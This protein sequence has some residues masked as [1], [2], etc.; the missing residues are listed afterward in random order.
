MVADNSEGL[1]GILEKVYHARG[2]DFR[3]YKETTITR[4]L[5]RR[6]RAR[7]VKTY[8]E[9]ARV[10]DQDP[11]EYDRLFNDLTIKVTD[12][13]RDQVAFRALEEVAVPALTRDVTISIRI[14]SAGCSTGQEPYS[15]AML[16][17]ELSGRA[18][19]RWQV[20]ILAT[21]IDTEVLQRAQ[22]GRFSSKEV[23][24]I[25]VAWLEK[26]FVRE[27]KGFRIQSLLKGLVTFKVHDLINDLPYSDVDLVVCRNV[28]IYFGHELQMKVLRG[29]HRALQPEGFLLLGRAE[30]LMGEATKLFQC[31]DRRARLYKK[32]PVSHRSANERE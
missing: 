29:F 8:A 27:A 2:L 20:N 7:G 5:S 11:A 28:L 21:D 9:Y 1:H 25:P 32:Q 13:F 31:V 22:E 6:L 30:V 12:F 4:R 10:L 16:L 26:Y 23:S 19:A 24:A 3:G 14:W 17:V 15:I 18:N